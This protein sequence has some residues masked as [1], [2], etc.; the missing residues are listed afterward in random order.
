MHVLLFD[1]L[2]LFLHYVDFGLSLGLLESEP[3][4]G[5]FGLDAFL[6]KPLLEVSDH[7]LLGCLGVLRVLVNE[8]AHPLD[9]GLGVVEK[10]LVF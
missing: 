8:V 3:L 6:R 9:F 5:L 4:L 7:L 2:K 10:L 1:A